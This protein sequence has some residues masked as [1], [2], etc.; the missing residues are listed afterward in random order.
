LTLFEDR[1]FTEIIKFKYGG[2]LVQYNWY[3]NKKREIWRQT[4]IK[5]RL[6]KTHRE[7]HHMQ[8]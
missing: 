3:L 1:V 5:G 7:N 8:F 6:D 2:F 4:P